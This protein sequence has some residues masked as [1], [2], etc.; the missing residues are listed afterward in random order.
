MPLTNPHLISRPIAGATGTVTSANQIILDGTNLVGV[1]TGAATTQA[2][3]ERVDA[4]GVGAAIVTFTGSFTAQ[5]SNIDTW[6]DGRQQTRLRCTD[7]GGI[8]PVVFSL[9]GTTALNTAFD[10]LVTNNLPEVI[11]FV[12]EYTETTGFM[13]VQPRDGSAPQIGGTSVVIVRPNV[14]ATLEVTRSGGT[15]S[16]FVFQSIG[17]IGDT[18][19]GTLDAI[20]LINPSTAVWD[21]SDTTG[22][23]SNAVVKGNAYQVVNVPSGSGLVLDEFMANDDWV[24]WDAETFSSWTT[25]PHNWFV[26][27]AHEVRRISALEQ[28]FLN[29]TQVTAESDRNSITRGTAYA[30]DVGEIRLKLYATRSAYS[31][32]DLNTTGDIDEYTDP[33]DQTAY[34]GIRL[35]GNQAA[36]AATLPTLYVYAED[37]SGNFTRLLN[38]ADDFT[39]E[40]DFGAESDYLS[41]ETIHYTADNFLRIYYGAVVDRFNNPDLDIS[42]GNLDASLQARVDGSSGGGA[43]DGERLDALES[44]VAALFPLTPDVD[45]LT[46]FSDIFDPEATAGSVN[47]TDG[48]SLIA[49]YRGPSTR[50]ESA[51]VTYDDTGSNVVRYAGLGNNLYRTFGFDIDTP[52]Q[53]DDVTLTGTS[54]TANINVAGVNYL[55]T[56]NTNLT[57]TASDFVTSHS[58]ALTA[59]GIT[60][61]SNAAVLTFTANVG[62]T[63]FTIAAPVNA[64]GDLAG[65]LDNVTSRQILMWVVDGSELIPLFDVTTGG[66]FRANH[67]TPSRT[68]DEVVTG[69]T[70]FLQRSGS[71][72]LRAGTE[73]V[74]TFTITPFPASA[75]Q[76]SRRL[77]FDV[78]VYVN[79]T[80]TD[81]GHFE[82]VDLPADNTAAV[83]ISLTANIPLGPLYRNRSVTVTYTYELRVSG[84]DLLV[85][86][87]LVSAPSDVTIAF[88]D[89][90]TFLNYTAPN[91][92]ARVDD[93][94]NF[95]N[96]AGDYNATGVNELLVTFHPHINDNAM[97]AVAVATTAAGVVTQFNDVVIPQPHASFA[98]VEIPDT[99]AVSGFEF[100][101][102]SPEHFLTHSDL[103]HLVT[104]RATQWAYGLA[105]NQTITERQITEAIDFTQGLLLISPDASRW[106]VAVDDAGALSTTKQP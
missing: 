8:S 63:A 66:K 41:R 57:T 39:F 88:G 42:F 18:T 87:K 75:T 28:E 7:D 30:D 20:K 52:A 46:A 93:F 29:V 21:A 51:G 4:T 58:A 99:T 35:Q 77:Q 91:V 27:P 13:R 105:L 89:V 82:A 95:D 54:G 70:H 11:R 16:D 55:A 40:G 67:Y 84:G 36:L 34:L 37:T 104:R 50:Y 26:I 19:G 92:I 65:T 3:L 79:G 86:F 61:T 9:P 6:F 76:T 5:A 59:A 25:T 80:N 47:I 23:P 43:V 48:Y 17:G 24:V 83:P 68:E 106:L 56:F 60:V 32:A 2:A 90:A 64:T 1:A 69:E 31:A 74:Q 78:E 71:T 94:Q 10:T 101:T 102:F 22:L 12:L 45:D 33:S 97:E 49:D 85:D 53:V 73:D 81:A 100:R 72:T 38:L 14:A 103:A 62:G 96:A 44:K 98:S 15:I